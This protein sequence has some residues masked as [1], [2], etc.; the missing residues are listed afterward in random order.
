L[1]TGSQFGHNV[2]DSEWQLF[3]REQ[4]QWFLAKSFFSDAPFEK[5]AEVIRSVPLETCPPPFNPVLP[6]ALCQLGLTNLGS[7]VYDF[8]IKVEENNLASDIKIFPNPATNW[9]NVDV[10]SKYVAAYEV[11]QLQVY[12]MW[13]RPL[14]LKDVVPNGQY[15]I[16]VSGL[17]EGAYVLKIGLGASGNAWKRFFINR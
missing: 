13:N 3:V 17:P 11:H 10:N 5:H 7:V 1:F 4:I 2:F 6:G 16:D 9:L 12:D 15:E 14:L 8:P